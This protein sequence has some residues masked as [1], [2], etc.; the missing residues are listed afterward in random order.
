MKLADKVSVITGAASGIGRATADLFA[1]EGAR[2]VA[3]DRDES[4]LAGLARDTAPSSPSPRSWRRPAAATTS[5]TSHP[6]VPSSR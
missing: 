3:V 5:P 1:H 2:T 4:A 6:R